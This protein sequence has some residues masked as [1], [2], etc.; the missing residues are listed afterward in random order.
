ML[1][2]SDKVVRP[3][4]LWCDTEAA[5][6][7]EELSNAFDFQI[8]PGF[9]GE[10]RHAGLGRC[11]AVRAQHAAEQRR[12]LYRPQTALDA[13]ARTG[14]LRCHGY[15]VLASFIHDLRAYRSEGVRAHH[16]RHRGSSQ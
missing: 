1:D 11:H 10:A 4:K 5:P 15:L 16:A 6:E 13:T 14:E 7:A 8:P 3:A 12:L 2:K 9:T